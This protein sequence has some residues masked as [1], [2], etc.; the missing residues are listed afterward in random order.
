M[1]R[2]NEIVNKLLKNRSFLDF[3]VP[4]NY[5]ISDFALSRFSRPRSLQTEE[6]W[7]DLQKQQ[8]FSDRRKSG[9]MLEMGDAKS[10]SLSR[11]VQRVQPRPSIQPIIKFIFSPRFVGLETCDKVRRLFLFPISKQNKNLGFSHMKSGN[12]DTSRY[13]VLSGRSAVVSDYTANFS[14]TKK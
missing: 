7:E 3:V 8:N 11:S 2:G 14:Q 9:I 5:I 10:T 13:F 6:K 12:P 1:L 4:L